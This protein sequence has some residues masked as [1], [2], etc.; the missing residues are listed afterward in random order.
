MRPRISHFIE[1]V[2]NV[3]KGETAPFLS[4]PTVSS[5]SVGQTEAKVRPKTQWPSFLFSLHLFGV[6]LLSCL[7]CHNRPVLFVF[8]L[9][10][11]IL[12]ETCWH[13]R[14][15]QPVSACP[16][17]SP[18]LP[19]PAFTGPQILCGS[20][21]EPA[22][23]SCQDMGFFLCLSPLLSLSHTLLL[24]GWGS[25]VFYIRSYIFWTTFPAWL[26]AWSFPLK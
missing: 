24:S 23:T 18:S 12:L 22:C 9:F 8:P 25:E 15:F 26:F 1:T 6:F 19:P 3:E 4:P 10:S 11:T 7:L 14:T 16:R 21:W 20:L 2:L 13:Q 17:S 5:M